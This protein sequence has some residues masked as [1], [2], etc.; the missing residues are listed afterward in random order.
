MLLVAER[1]VKESFRKKAFWIT[2]G[3]LLLGSLAIVIVPSLLDSDSD[4]RTVLVVGE[5][6]PD[7]S[8]AVVAASASF[9]VDV[10]FETVA[11][12]ATA[13]ERVTDGDAGPALV[14]GDPTSRLLQRT[15][16]FDPVAAV[17]Q[18]ALRQSAVDAVAAEAGIDPALLDE[19]RAVAPVELVTLDT[20]R[21]GRQTA[22]FTLTLVMYVIIMLLMSVVATSVATEKANRVSEVLLAVAKPRSLLYGKVLGVA[23]VGVIT[24]V[25]GAV[26]II[27]RLLVGGGLPE[28]LG[29]TLLS[30]GI[31]FLGGIVQYL[32]LAAALGSLADRTEEAGGAVAPLTG[33]L[34]GVYV[35]TLA[36]LESGL[37][38]VLS[39]F[40]LSSP[41]MMPA[42]IAIGAAEPWEIA[43][44]LI[45]LVIGVVGLTLLA[46]SIY[47][48]AIT[49]TGR[50]LKFTE[51]I[52]QT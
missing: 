27:V 21:D 19:V 39:I 3:G 6:A 17:L 34:V 8:D 35:A 22:A 50:K 20:A 15:N 18:E 28:A 7:V 2:L 42:R 16:G 43:A 38:V 30:S 49:R 31:W 29:A 45:A 32:V 48:K 26:P 37:G 5:L 10:T 40:P 51:V 1:E 24:V 14:V 36:T 52:R 9:D 23:I 13:A 44:S 25:G 47:G 41:I 33:L 12:E 11:D 4:E 46:G